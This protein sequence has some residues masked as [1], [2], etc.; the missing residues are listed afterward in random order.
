MS[1]GM[2]LIGLLLILAIIA[3]GVGV[4]FKNDSLRTIIMPSPALESEKGMPS[5]E[6]RF[7]DAGEN[8]EI[9]APMTKVTLVANGESHDVGTYEG[10]CS[11]IEDSA[12]PYLDNEVTGVI[13]WFAGGGSEI[14]VFREN[15]AI[16]VKAGLLDEGSAEVEGTRGDFTTLLEL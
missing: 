11:K 10:S 4:A 15:G 5:Y 6:W 16:L 2:G 13:C 1:K 7:E 14:G 12:W 3:L 9:G 8:E